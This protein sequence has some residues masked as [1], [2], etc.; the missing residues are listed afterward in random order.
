MTL[1]TKPIWQH[2]IVVLGV[3]A[4][5]VGLVL[6]YFNR[7]KTSGVRRIVRMEPWSWNP[8]IPTPELIGCFP[9]GRKSVQSA[10]WRRDSGVDTRLCHTIADSYK[11]KGVR[12]FGVAPGRCRLWKEPPTG[13]TPGY[14]ADGPPISKEDTQRVCRTDKEAM[15]TKTMNVV[16]RIQ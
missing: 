5:V 7:P 3:V 1:E 6:W 16:Y 11:G 13:Q 8:D 14:A 4:T 15:G 12:Y 10:A 9:E 2:P